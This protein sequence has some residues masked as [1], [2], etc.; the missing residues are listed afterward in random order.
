MIA[1]GGVPGK[2]EPSAWEYFFP[3]LPAMRDGDYDTA[4]AHPRRAA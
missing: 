1:I 3:A 4:R 2:H